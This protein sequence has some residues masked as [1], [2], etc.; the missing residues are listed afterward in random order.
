MQ[1]GTRL[2]L[3]FRHASCDPI[4]SERFKALVEVTNATRLRGPVA[5]RKRRAPKQIAGR[6]CTHCE[7]GTFSAALRWPIPSLS[8]WWDN[9]NDQYGTVYI[10]VVVL[11]RLPRESAGCRRFE[12]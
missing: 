6:N 12:R 3:R 8:N 4:L 1:V 11:I 7:S 2:S 5:M 9:Q 10:P